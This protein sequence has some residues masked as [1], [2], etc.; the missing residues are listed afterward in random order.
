MLETVADLELIEYDANIIINVLIDRYF[1]HVTCQSTTSSIDKLIN[2]MVWDWRQKIDDETI[3]F[4][5]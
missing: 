3:H 1:E 2:E 5:T 4:L